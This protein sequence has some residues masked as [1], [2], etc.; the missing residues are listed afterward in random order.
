MFELTG[1]QK[2]ILRS[3]AQKVPSTVH[4]GKAGVNEAVLKQIDSQLEIHE[5]VKIRLPAGDPKQRKA[6]AA[7][8]AESLDAGLARTTGRTAILYRPNREL[9]AKKRIALP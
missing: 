8:I 6:K 5:L 1:K 3:L 4:V 2:R 7:E 9:E